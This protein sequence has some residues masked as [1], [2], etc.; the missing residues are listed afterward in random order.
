M[1]IS[2]LKN[3]NLILFEA[4]SGSKAYGTDLPTSDEDIKGIF[5]LPKKDFYGLDYIPQVSDERNDI[6]YYELKRFF[7]LLSKNNPNILELLATPELCILKSHPLLKKIKP[8]LFLSKLCQKTFAGY[9]IAQIKKARGL[10]KK[11]LNPV[12]KE[13][14][15]VLDFCYLIKGHGSTSLKNWLS[16]NQLKQENCGLVNIAHFKDTYAVFHDETGELNFR[17]IMQK[18]NSNEVTLSSIPKGIEPLGYMTFNKDGYKTYCKDYREYWDWV[19]KRNEARYENTISHGKNYD[20]KNMLHT[21]RL[22]DMAAEIAKEKKVIVRRPNRD[23]LLDIRAGKFQYDELVKWA[24]EKIEEIEKL[25]E[26][27]DLPERPDINKIE[28]LLFEIREE[29]YKK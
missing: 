13:K 22:L 21:F 20:A 1:T 19:K 23:F 8:E 3:R 29:W 16:K 4:I 26:I 28:E 2:D 27:A 14:K 10:N 15:S 9:A 25:Y 11:I 12:D 17:G 6:V 5:I 7:D 24:D 18:E